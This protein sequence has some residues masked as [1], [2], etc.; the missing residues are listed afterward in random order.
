MQTDHHHA[1]GIAAEIQAGVGRAEQFHQ[2]VVDDLDDLLAGL[3]ALDD[4]LADGLGLDALDEIAGDLE[5][6]IRLEQRHAHLAQGIGD[7]G[8]GDFAEAAQVFERVLE[9]RK[10]L[11]CFPDQQTPLRDCLK[12]WLDC[13]L[14]CEVVIVWLAH[15]GGRDECWLPPHPHR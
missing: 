1:G 12:N 3:D 13:G 4:L 2:F 7:V 10:F 11:T 6:D 9:Q 5:I 14:T 8:L 15:W